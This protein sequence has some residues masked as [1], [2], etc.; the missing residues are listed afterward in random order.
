M[1]KIIY[2]MGPS[3]SGKDSII[4]AVRE[5]CIKDLQVAHRYITRPWMSGGEN[6]IALSNAEYEQRQQLGLFSFAWS[7]NQHHYAIGREIESWLEA[8]Q[9]VLINGS[10]AYLEQAMHTYPDSLCPVLVDVSPVLLEKRLIERARESKA[11]I[12]ARIQ[13][14]A[15]YRDS[16]PK[17]CEII[18]NNN[19]IT[20]AIAQLISIIKR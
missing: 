4:N 2:L 7:A 15:N 1:S 13:R 6:H 18:D 19:D 5:H 20:H 10:R 3:G 9:N 17:G 8:G 11:E 12:A 14:H 16:A